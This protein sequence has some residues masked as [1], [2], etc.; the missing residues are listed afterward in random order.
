MNILFSHMWNTNNNIYCVITCL[1]SIAPIT[2]QQKGAGTVPRKALKNV[3]PSPSNSMLL[4]VEITN[5][6]LYI[7][8]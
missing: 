3:P 6:I 4:I 7:I 8:L 1:L 5:I 2:K